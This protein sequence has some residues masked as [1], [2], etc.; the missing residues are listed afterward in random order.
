MSFLDRIRGNR[1]VRKLYRLP[2]AARAYHLALAAFGAAATGLPSR[3]LTVIGVT[4]DIRGGSLES[5]YGQQ[6]WMP[7]SLGHYPPTR[8]LVRAAGPGVITADALRRAV[9]TV[10]PDIALAHIRT[11]DDIVD[12]ATSR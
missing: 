7:Q 9:R 6:V 4:G 1:L 12:R 8:L 5:S 3:R 11:M 2:G 10:D